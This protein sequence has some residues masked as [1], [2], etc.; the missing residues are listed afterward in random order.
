MRYLP[1]APQG[2]TIGVALVLRDMA[3]R[4]PYKITLSYASAS[5]VR[6]RTQCTSLLWVSFLASAGPLAAGLVCLAGFC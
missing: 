6:S 5:V 3:D 1:L 2:C 4:T